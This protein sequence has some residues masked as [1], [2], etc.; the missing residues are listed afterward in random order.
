MENRCH[1][2]F[3]RRQRPLRST[4]YVLTNSFDS[5]V[6]NAMSNLFNRPVT[7]Q[8]LAAPIKSIRKVSCKNSKRISLLES[9]FLIDFN[10]FR[11]LHFNCI[12][13]GVAT[14]KNAG[15]IKRAMIKINSVIKLDVAV[16]KNLL[17]A[18]WGRLNGRPKFKLHKDRNVER[19]ISAAVLEMRPSGVHRHAIRNPS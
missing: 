11:V 5:L 2:L 15:R 16:S 13:Y 8:F 12:C 17:K 4:F 1:L 9:H 19:G 6:E 3:P 7:E 10:S 18:R 14:H